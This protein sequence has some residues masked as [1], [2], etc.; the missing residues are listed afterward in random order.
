MSDAEQ[1][2]EADPERAVRFCATLAPFAISPDKRERLLSRFPNLSVHPHALGYRRLFQHIVYG[3]FQDRLLPTGGAVVP[4]D[5][6]AHCQGVHPKSH[7]FNALR[8][9][10]AFS[11]DVFPLRIIAHSYIEGRARVVCPEMP[12]D[13]AELIGRIRQAHISHLNGCLWFDTGEPVSRR[14]LK[15]RQDEYAAHLQAIEDMVPQDHPA[16]RIVHH[17][18]KHRP[19]VARVIRERLDRIRED[20]AALPDGPAAWHSGRLLGQL[21]IFPYVYYGVSDR[22]VRLH[23]LG[24]NPHQFPRA[25]RKKLFD[26]LIEADLKAAQLSIVARL[27]DVESLQALLR[28]GKSVWQVLADYARLPLATYKPQLK[29]TMYSIV[30]GMAKVNLIRQLTDGEPLQPETAL[31]RRQALRLLRHPVLKELLAARAQ[32]IKRVNWDGGAED[33]YGQWHSVGLG[34]SARSVLAHVVQ[35]HEL[36]LME[37]VLDVLDRQ[38]QLYLISWLHDGVSLLPGNRT[39][40]ERYCRQLQEGVALRAQELGYLTELEVDFE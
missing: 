23:A 15:A 31:S 27:W 28:E 16:R 37:P 13:A 30:F 21:E 33:A 25:L 19:K 11:E 20:I 32:Q 24:S 4:F 10:E 38:P 17:V 35:S 14:S 36:K 22:T 2:L 8:F 3:P 18:R 29:R 9:L 6:V 34:R 7:G 1:L 5:L 12:A 39:K 26:G 40:A